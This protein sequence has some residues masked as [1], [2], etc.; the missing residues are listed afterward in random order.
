MT[1]C[2][3]R[4]TD[5]RFR[6]NAMQFE[7]ISG[8]RTFVN[9]SGLVDWKWNGRASADGFAEYL[10]RNSDSVGPDSVPTDE[11][12]TEI[13][14]EYLISVGENPSDYGVSSTT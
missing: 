4:F 12:Y 8:A 2:L 3:S 6:R 5:K 14:R 11:D 1:Y 9:S 7:T 13:L 10:F